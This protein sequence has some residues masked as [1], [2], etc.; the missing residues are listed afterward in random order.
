MTMV[1]PLA[2]A[3]ARS[4]A[5]PSVIEA[6]TLELKPGVTAPRFRS[7]D[8]AVEIQHVTRQ[9]GFLSRESAA[10]ARFMMS[11]VPDSMVRTR[12]GKQ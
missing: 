12:H 6:V 11:I 5:A 10:A 1:V 2:A 7:I 4:T 3:N 9:S 8:K